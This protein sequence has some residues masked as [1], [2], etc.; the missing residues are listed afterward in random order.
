MYHRFNSLYLPIYFGLI[1]THRPMLLLRFFCFSA[2]LC[3]LG[4]YALP[5]MEVFSRGGRTS[6]PIKTWML[7]ISLNLFR[8]CFWL[9]LV[10]TVLRRSASCFA[11]SSIILFVSKEMLPDLK[12]FIFCFLLSR[13]GENVKPVIPLLTKFGS[14]NLPLNLSYKCYAVY[15]HL[16][17]SNFASSLYAYVRRPVKTFLVYYWILAFRI[18][19]LSSM[20]AEKLINLGLIWMKFVDWFFLLKYSRVRYPLLLLASCSLWL[21]LIDGLLCLLKWRWIFFFSIKSILI[22]GTFYHSFIVC[23]PVGSSL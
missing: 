6:Y 23:I 19:F 13:S 4:E 21:I 22:S 3:C 1:G 17:E 14:S 18:L 2:L 5:V 11:Y 12:S 9:G 20:A 7:D 15:S 8:R 10:C 16:S